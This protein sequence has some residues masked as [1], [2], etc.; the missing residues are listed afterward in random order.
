MLTEAERSEITAALAKWSESVP[1]KPL[2]G[3]L[4]SERFLTPREIVAEVERNTP[5]GQAVLEMLEH[6]L[7]REGMEAVV[8]RLGRRHDRWAFR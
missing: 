8:S 4:G 5:D 2:L 1:D 3:F 6:G 7:R